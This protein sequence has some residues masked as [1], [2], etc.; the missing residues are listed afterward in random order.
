L[1]LFVGAIGLLSNK[2][3]ESWLHDLWAG[4][5]WNG[6]PL[7]TTKGQ[8][9]YVLDPG[10]W[11]QD[12]GPDFLLAKIFID[13]V[14]WVGSVEIHLRAIDWFRHNHT[15]DPHYFPV[16]LH[17]VWM[18]D[19]HHPDIP[20]L[21]LSR[22]LTVPRLREL[23]RLM[24]RLGE[25]PCHKRMRPVPEIVWKQWRCELLSHRLNRKKF[26]FKNGP[27]SFRNRLARQMG[28]W[29][30][31][32]IFES[33][34]ATI[35]DELILAFRSDRDLVTAIYL[36][37]S[38]L[39][40]ERN[41]DLFLDKLFVIYD[42][43]RAKH[44]LNPPY[45]QLLWMRIRPAANPLFRMVQ[46]AQLIHG[47]WQEVEK[48]NGRTSDE[49]R[50]E[51]KE[52]ALNDYWIAG[53]RTSFSESTID[54]LLIN[55]WAYLE[56]TTADELIIRLSDFRFENNRFTR[57][58]SSLELAAITAADSQAMLEL[59]EYFC[60]PNRCSACLLERYWCQDQAP[61]SI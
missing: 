14:L 54:S 52:M 11:N 48:W 21:E 19:P 24:S 41:G 61:Q 25:L 23:L 15:V 3:R 59:N 47:E 6:W 50:M 26:G 42:K 38:G 13:Q 44:A 35:S 7:R 17:V 34:D 16:I 31:R 8:S 32:E 55:L 46:L 22:F 57:L 1:F 43:L 58:Y 45:R 39:L 56:A 5:D 20:T 30:N 51:L 28:A 29:V 37:Q 18:Q 49:I 53:R 40:S 12:Q 36:G 60:Q 4:Q 9:L 27:G 10:K 33:I 2:M